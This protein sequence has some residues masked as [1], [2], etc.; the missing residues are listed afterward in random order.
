MSLPLLTLEIRLEPDIVLARQR[1]RQIAGLM[2]FAPLDQTRIAT[3]VSE[4]ARNAFQYGGGGKIE[5]LVEPGLAPTF[6]IRVRERGQGIKDLQAILDGSYDSPT[7]LGLGILGAKRLMD[8]FHIESSENGATVTMAKGLPK[9][10]TPF[11]AQDVARVSAELAQHGALSLIQEIQLQNQELLRT[12]QELRERQAELAELHQKE[13]DDT[14][15]GVV[16][17]YSELDATAIEL[18]RISDLKSRFLSN[19]SHEFRS[20]LNTI[21]SMSG[22]LLDGSSGELNA[23]QT[24]EIEFIRT[25]AEGLAA[26]VSDLLDLAKVEAGKAVIRLETFA[27]ADLF[28]GLRKMTSPLVAHRPVSVVFEDLVGLLTLHTDEGKV[29]QILRN[30]VTNA[31]KFTELGEIRI[32]ATPGP[33]DTVVFSVAD[34]GIGIA[35]E[36]QRLIFEEFAQVEGP[37]QRRVKGTGLGLPLS[38]KL[39]ELLGG[40]VSVRSAPGVGSTFF[41]VIPRSYRQAGNVEAAP[42]SDLR[43]DPARTPVLVGEAD[44]TELGSLTRHEPLPNVLI[45]DDGEDDRYHLSRLLTALGR[46]AIVEAVGGAEGLRRARESR[47]DVI[48]LDLVMADMTGFETLE[49]LRSDEALKEIPVII[50][51]SA[52]LGDEE[53]RRLVSDTTAVLSKSLGKAGEASVAIRDAL[54]RAGLNLTSMGPES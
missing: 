13:L 5:F 44:P 43:L 49:Q 51:T 36:D 8:Q 2:G 41:A 29:A 37:L 3:A 23:E 4:I 42:Q 9:R 27:V 39:A 7:G 12:L 53:R 47:P 11:A 50:N 6:V 18:K 32:A 46:F 34:T 54:I 48:F 20:P 14:N 10:L 22:F 19:M 33:D 24:K 26:L 28:E 31:A 35:P 30:F 40:E 15:R 25:S 38:R 45:I 52:D 21:L 1:A 16:A 17:L